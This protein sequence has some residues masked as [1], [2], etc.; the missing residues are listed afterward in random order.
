MVNDNDCL[1]SLV[2]ITMTPFS[3]QQVSQND[4]SRCF[5]GVWCALSPV[6][7]VSR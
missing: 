2:V 5:F 7:K 4:D 3:V 1:K 6:M